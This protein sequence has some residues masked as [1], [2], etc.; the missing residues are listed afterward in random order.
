MNRYFTKLYY[1]NISMC[2]IAIVEEFE[3]GVLH[4]MYV[5]MYMHVCRL[6]SSQ[7]ASWGN[8]AVTIA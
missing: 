1:H 6:N 7:H 5:C 8:L 3:V 2:I 4:A